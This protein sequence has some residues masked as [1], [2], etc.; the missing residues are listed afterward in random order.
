MLTS[1]EILTFLRNN[2]LTLKNKYFVTEI[3]LFGSFARDE[4]NENS[5]ID[6]LVIFEPDTPDLYSVEKELKEYLKNHFNREVDISA[7]KWINPVFKPLILK[8]AVYA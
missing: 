2:K 8:E 3:G 1:G 5:D 6:F 7:K 4:Q